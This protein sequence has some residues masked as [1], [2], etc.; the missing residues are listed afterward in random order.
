[1]SNI[2]HEGLAGA[3]KGTYKAHILHQVWATNLA[4]NQKL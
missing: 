1:M 2:V 3:G 4:S